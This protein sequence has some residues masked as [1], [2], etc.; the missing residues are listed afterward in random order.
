MQQMGVAGQMNTGLNVSQSPSVQQPNTPSMGSMPPSV[1][2]MGTI[3]GSGGLAPYPNSSAISTEGS[4]TQLKSTA[5][6]SVDS[7]IPP[8][9]L[10]LHAESNFDVSGLGG[11][12][13]ATGPDMRGSGSVSHEAQVNTD[14]DIRTRMNEFVGTMQVGSFRLCLQ[15]ILATTRFLSTVNPRRDRE[16]ITCSNYALAQKILMRNAA[17]EAEMVGI[18]GG[19]SQAVQKHIESALL[20]MFLAELKHI[21]PRHRMAAMKI[22]VEKNSIVGNYGMCAR[23][24]RQLVQKAPAG[25][26]QEFEKKLEVCVR[27]GERNSHMPPTNRLCYNSLQ[28]VGSPYV[29]CAVCSAVYH[30]LLSGLVQGQVCGVCFVGSVTTMI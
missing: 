19:S 16:I 14:E 6:R 12:K 26:K 1:P 3:P 7:S 17:V 10:A 22:A 28:V 20:T 9:L 21:Q 5:K 18:Q 23:W 30:P 8:A 15:Q 13:D 24:L 25:Q 29:K 11:M 4:S 2:S 27:N